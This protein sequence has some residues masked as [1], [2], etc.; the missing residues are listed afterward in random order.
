MLI[1]SAPRFA[2]PSEMSSAGML[3]GRCCITAFIG[4]WDFGLEGEVQKVTALKVRPDG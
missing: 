3:N 1:M 4:F 2:N